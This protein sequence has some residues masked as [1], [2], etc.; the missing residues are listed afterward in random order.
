MQTRTSLYKLYTK[1]KAL[2]I[3]IHQAS[4]P[5]TQK[6]CIL[7]VCAL[8][9]SARR[10]QLQNEQHEHPR[11][12]SASKNDFPHDATW[13]DSF[14]YINTKLKCTYIHINTNITCAQTHTHIIYNRTHIHTY[15]HT[16]VTNPNMALWRQASSC[17]LFLQ[18]HVFS[19]WM[20]ASPYTHI[21]YEPNHLLHHGMFIIII[22]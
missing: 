2:Y 12:L 19:V 16:Y 18:V 4:V 22:K 9:C 14:F 10:H 11:G 5:L 6:S 8:R 17:A 3:S 20:R 15:I 1:S 13:Q 21:L 7:C